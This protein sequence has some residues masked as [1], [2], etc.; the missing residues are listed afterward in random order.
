VRWARRLL[1]AAGVAVMAY[2]VAGAAA[3]PQTR[4]V[5]HLLFLAAVVVAHDAVLMPLTIATGVLIGRFLPLPVRR[6]VRAAA[7]VSLAVT[8]VALPFVLGRGRRPDDPSALP[9]DYG[10]GLLVVLAL[11]WS[12]ALIAAWRAR[13][14]AARERAEPA[15]SAGG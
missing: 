6:P 2:A 14:R 12:A 3:D 4:P 10:H 7:L 8:L 13:R 9:L 5:G 1:V 11:V 15:G